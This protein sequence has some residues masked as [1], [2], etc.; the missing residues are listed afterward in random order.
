MVERLVLP[1][2][3]AR[4][5]EDLICEARAGAF[6]GSRDFAEGIAREDQDMDVVR[7]YDPGEKNAQLP[8]FGQE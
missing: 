5:A 7:H 2:G 4:S 8:L 6:Y 1:E 3:P